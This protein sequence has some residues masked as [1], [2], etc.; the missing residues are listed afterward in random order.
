MPGLEGIDGS[1]KDKGLVALMLG[2]ESSFHGCCRREDRDRE[3]LVCFDSEFEEDSRL[4]SLILLLDI[5]GGE[6][7]SEFFDSSSHR[8]SDADE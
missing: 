8:D 7:G 5:G 4:L 6:G 3:D 1:S 2:S